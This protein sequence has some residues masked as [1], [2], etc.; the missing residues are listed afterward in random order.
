MK[1]NIMKIAIAGVL[2][3]GLV[4]C[5]EFLNRPA[6]DNYNV[7]NFY[8]ND[9]QCIQG[10]NYLYNSPWFDFQRA[11]LWVGEIMSGNLYIG[12]SKYLDFSV[13]GTDEDLKNMSYSLWAVNGL[14]ILS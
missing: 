11:F 8:Q 7:D 5:D 1:T 4:S 6:E 14:P 9:A 13:N 12:E 3:M 2:A 10:V